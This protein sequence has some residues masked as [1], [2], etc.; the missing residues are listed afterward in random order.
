[1]E[2]WSSLTA[3]S[4]TTE[5]GE[6]V[7]PFQEFSFLPLLP[8]LVL[9]L[10]L[11]G[12]VPIGSSSSWVCLTAARGKGLFWFISV[13]EFFLTPFARERHIDRST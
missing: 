6:R 1:M 13:Q 5:K 9:C 4:H 3:P 12:T 7:T 10:L 8:L 2:A 11:F